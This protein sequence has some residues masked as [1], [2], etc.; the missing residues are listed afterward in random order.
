MDG[1]FPSAHLPAC[2]ASLSIPAR[3]GAVSHQ[4]RHRHGRGLEARSSRQLRTCRRRWKHLPQRIRRDRLRWSACRA[5]KDVHKVDGG[6]GEM[7][8]LLREGSARV[9]RMWQRLQEHSQNRCDNHRAPHTHAET[10]RAQLWSLLLVLSSCIGPQMV[11]PCC[12]ATATRLE[13]GET[14]R[15]A[16]PRG[17]CRR[18]PLPPSAAHR[19]TLRG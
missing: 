9:H 12:N 10:P 2:A 11:P 4:R 8:A 13:R 16:R 7:P 17:A 1:M 18:S 3:G 19:L 15:S 5:D 6:G 14:G